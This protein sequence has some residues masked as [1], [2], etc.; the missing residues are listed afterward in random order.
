[1]RPGELMSTPAT[2]LL[3]AEATFTPAPISVIR[4]AAHSES[5]S[6]GVCEVDS[7]SRRRADGPTALAS[8]AGPRSRA[9]G[10]LLRTEH[11]RRRIACI[12]SREE[13]APD[14]RSQK[15]KAAHC[16]FIFALV[17]FLCSSSSSA[18]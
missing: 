14:H 15:E 2:P 1:M 3:K 11:L 17:L 8:R 9:C 4:L 6:A 10:R 13:N 5:G 16:I 18:W 12:G 7:S